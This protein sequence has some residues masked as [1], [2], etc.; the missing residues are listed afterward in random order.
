MISVLG[1]GIAGVG[2]RSRGGV[3]TIDPGGLIVGFGAPRLTDTQ[4]LNDNV[5]LNNNVVKKAL[6]ERLKY[7]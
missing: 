5:M 3:L 7:F 6:C 2:L 1:C 4:E